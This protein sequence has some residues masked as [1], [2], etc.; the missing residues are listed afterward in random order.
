MACE[1]RLVEALQRATLTNSE[2]QWYLMNTNQQILKEDTE[3]SSLQRR[4]RR[5]LALK[6]RETL[7]VIG[8]TYCP[9]AVGDLRSH[10]SL[11][12]VKDLE[13]GG[14]NIDASSARLAYTKSIPQ[15]ST[16]NPAAI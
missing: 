10:Q 14:A 11:R 1:H 6:P 2:T 13:A 16:T 7:S 15:A 9:P 8:L 5:S 12:P 4:S 3:S